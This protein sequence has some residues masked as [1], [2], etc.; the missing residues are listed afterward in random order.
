MSVLRDPFVD[1]RD[2]AIV[3]RLG[4]AFLLL[5][6][7]Y[8]VGRGT[9]PV[10]EPGPEE[11]VAQPA[12]KNIELPGL[13][14]NFQKRCVDL[15]ATICLDAGL[16]ELIACTKGSKEHESIV[17]VAARPMHIHTA[18]LCWARIMATRP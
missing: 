7:F 6:L 10:Q 1:S 5:A 18:L 9:M 8:S 12:R 3:S 17:A 11:S 16:L 2:G 14:I 13:L 15:E 4:W